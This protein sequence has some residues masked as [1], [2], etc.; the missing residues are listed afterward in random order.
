VRRDGRGPRD[1]STAGTAATVA[2]HPVDRTTFPLLITLGLGVFAGALDL[3]VLSPALPALGAAFGVGPRELAWVFTLYLLANVVAIPVM[4]KLADHYGR[5][6]AY[7]ACVTIFALGSVFA[8][9]APSFGLFLAARAVQAIGAGGIFPVATA[10]IADRVPLERRGAALGLVAAT[11]GLAAV[12]GPVLGGAITHFVSWRWVFALNIPLA[13]VVIAMAR[14]TVPARAARARGALDVAGIVTLAIALL[15]TMSLLSRL[16]V[17]DGRAN[18]PLAWAMLAVAVVALTLFALAE[19]RAQQ[20]VIPLAFFRDRQL[21]VTYALEVLIGA[22]EGALFF[23]PAALVAAQHLSY[24]AAG[25]VAAV[26]AFCFVAVIPLSG[27]ALD[28]VGSR[29]VLAVGGT[30]TALGM[31]IFALGL[32]DLRSALLAMVV[33]GVG[34]GALLGAPTRYIVTSR[35][36][37]Q[38]RASAVGLL[39]IMLIIGQ[40]VGGSLGGG[41]AESHGGVVQGY[42]IAY[43]VFTGVAVLAVILTAALASRARER[44]AAGTPR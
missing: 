5:R 20:P 10:A 6:P 2:G 12:I 27:R 28:V 24:A 29:A 3:G 35:A 37:E 7:I 16:Y 23:I 13:V 1:L 25:A 15:A 32:G 40:I 34:F 41:V 38:Q 39:S 31:L 44:A 42:R 8:I 36:G 4:S 43:L 9:A 26:G 21:V 33:A 11:W 30:L 14:T 17:V 19:R 22:L 18:E